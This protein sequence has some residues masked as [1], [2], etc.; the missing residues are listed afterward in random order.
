MWE[1]HESWSLLAAARRVMGEVV[2]GLSHF[3]IAIY[4]IISKNA[5]RATAQSGPNVAPPVPPRNHSI[6]GQSHIQQK[7]ATYKRFL[8]MPI[9]LKLVFNQRWYNIQTISKMIL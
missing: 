2:M 8:K 1:T 3:N 5:G 4:Y 6:A 9:T 7:R